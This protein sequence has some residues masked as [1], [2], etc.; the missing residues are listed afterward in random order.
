MFNINNYNHDFIDN[1]IEKCKENNFILKDIIELDKKYKNNIL[2]PL[3]KA[4]YLLFELKYLNPTL[5]VFYNSITNQTIKYYVSTNIEYNMNLELSEDIENSDGF[6]VSGLSP[7]TKIL[8]HFFTPKI[9]L[10][11]NNTNYVINSNDFYDEQ[12]RNTI[13]YLLYSN[14][15]DIITNYFDKYYLVIYRNGVK[16]ECKNYDEFYDNFKLTR[17]I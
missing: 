13:T 15:S 5:L 4:Q 6:I 1:L 14:K 3:Q 17:H 11:Y 8:D 12:K 16:I 10:G 2:T 7:S 9:F